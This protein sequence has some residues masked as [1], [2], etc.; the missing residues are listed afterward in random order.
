[1][2]A[3]IKKLVIINLLL[4]IGLHVWGQNTDNETLI[5]IGDRKVDTFQIELS[6]ND[7]LKAGK[8]KTNQ[9]GWSVNSYN[10]SMFALGNSIRCEVSDSMY[11]T[12]LRE[13][14]ENKKINY[15]YINIE[16]VKV[17]DKEGNISMP[18]IDTVKVKFIY[19]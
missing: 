5:V 10:F 18:K 14:V 6:K 15:R 19:K 12:K 13:S 1:M 16:G 9:K 8:I 11:S 2:T 3:I 7:F 4:L 17:I